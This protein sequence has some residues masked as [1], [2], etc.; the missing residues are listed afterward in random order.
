MTRKRGNQIVNHYVQNNTNIMITHKQTQNTTKND[1]NNDNNK[2]KPIRL[3]R[4]V[5]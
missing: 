3:K 4:N 2:I 5:I 1:T